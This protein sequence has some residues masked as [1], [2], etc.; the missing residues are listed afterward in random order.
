VDDTLIKEFEMLHAQVCH[1]L[2]DP[3]RLLMLY[4]LSRKAYSVGELADSLG[5]PQPTAS[6]HL[7]ILRERSLVEANRDGAMVFYS[8]KEAR[9]EHVIELLRSILRDRLHEQA[10]LAD[11]HDIPLSDEG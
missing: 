10:R 3:K 9:L 4:L 11:A 6:R 8:V 2:S 1:A 5:I 7:A